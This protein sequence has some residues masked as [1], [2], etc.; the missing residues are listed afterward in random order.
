[1]LPRSLEIKLEKIRWFLSSSMANM[2]GFFSI[3]GKDHSA[4]MVVPYNITK[5]LLRRW[6]AIVDTAVFVRGWENNDRVHPKGIKI[7]YRGKRE[8]SGD[9]KTEFQPDLGYTS[10]S[11]KLMKTAVR[12]DGEE[13]NR[14]S[15]GSVSLRTAHCRASYAKGPRTGWLSRDEIRLRTTLHCSLKHT[16]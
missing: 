8:S 7:W 2:H 16:C 6:V 10:S 1:M 12:S 13:D 9:E 4:N 3:D 14:G 15:A 11:R 5:Q